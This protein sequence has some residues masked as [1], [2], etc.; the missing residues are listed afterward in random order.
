MTGE[1][2]RPDALAEPI[3]SEAGTF[4]RVIAIDCRDGVIRGD[5]EDDFHGFGVTLTHDGGVIVDAQG[6]AGR[7]PWLTCAEAPG[8]LVALVGAPLSP[9]PTALFRHTDPRQQ[10]THLF[11]LACLAVAEA[12]QGGDRETLFEA[13][14]TDPAAGPRVARLF[15]NGDLAM[16]WR[17]EGQAIV[18]PAAY[19]GRTI[20]DFSSRTISGLAPGLASI[21]L[22]MRRVAGLALGRGFNVDAFASAAALERP[23]ACYSLQAAN[24][25]RALRMTG[26]VWTWP[27]RATLVTAVRSR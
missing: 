24:A 1:P 14:V 6:R 4:R 11:E 18:W 20:A 10:C 16:E 5:L 7:F 15:R 8:A 23:P 3:G 13:E 19:A 2:P 25:P 26:S 9:D 22:I 21:T 17:L 12:A 27:D